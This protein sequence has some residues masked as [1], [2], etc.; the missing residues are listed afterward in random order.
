MNAAISDA[1]LAAAAW[2]ATSRVRYHQEQYPAAWEA[3]RKG[4]ALNMT[5]LDFGFLTE[6]M[7]KMPDPLGV[8]K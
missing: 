7:A 3:V 8:F 5:S 2:Q 6:L 4:Q 1:P